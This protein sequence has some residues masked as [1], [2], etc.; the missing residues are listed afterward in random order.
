MRTLERQWWRRRSAQAAL[1]AAKE[2]SGV[3]SMWQGLREFWDEKQN[4]MGW[5]TIYRFDNIS[6][7][8]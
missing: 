8:S 6:S 3:E 7:N 1:M 5:A 2:I 4:N